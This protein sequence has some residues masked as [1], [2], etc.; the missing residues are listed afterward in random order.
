MRRK[1]IIMKSKII[2][3][4]KDIWND[5]VKRATF[6]VFLI[7]PLVSYTIAEALNQRS[8]S[9]FFGFVTGSPVTFLL[10]YIIVLFTLSFTLV[11]KKRIA[12]MLMISCVWTVS[13]THLTLPTT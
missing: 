10:N 4:F 5:K 13:Y 2:N 6:L 11:L 8:V 9:K 7:A 3:Y 12:P 1:V